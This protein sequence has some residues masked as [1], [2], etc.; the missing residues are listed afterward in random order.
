MLK[1]KYFI[2]LSALAGV[3]ACVSQTIIEFYAI[4]KNE[5]YNPITQTISYLG[6]PE[7]PTY[8]LMTIW[9]IIFSILFMLFS[10]GFWNFFKDRFKFTHLATA[11]LLVYGFGQG[12]GAGIFPMDVSAKTVSVS[13]QIHEIFS[14]LGDLALVLFPVVMLFYFKGKSRI[15]TLTITSLGIG[16]ILVFLSA[17]FQVIQSAIPYKGLWQRLFQMIYFIYFLFIA[18]QMNFKSRNI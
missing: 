1:S 7:S 10:L 12:I 17:K 3:L 6:N 11:F 9:S 14:G 5:G 2:K 13:H 16:F 15:F 4:S 18:F 8:R